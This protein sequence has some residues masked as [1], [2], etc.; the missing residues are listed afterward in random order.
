M[1]GSL[2]VP[3]PWASTTID[4][5]RSKEMTFERSFG[6]AKKCLEN[7]EAGYFAELHLNEYIESLQA[8]TGLGPE[9][10]VLTKRP[11]K[12]ATE[13]DEELCDETVQILYWETSLCLIQLAPT[14][15]LF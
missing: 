3:S 1:I 12:N 6:E 9:E 2:R 10:T 8:V 4:L 5:F 11:G 14:R 15:T 7:I 13:E